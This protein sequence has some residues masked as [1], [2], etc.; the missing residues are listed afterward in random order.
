MG[1]Q[2]LSDSWF[3]EAERIRAEVNP[4]VP[5]AVKDL[6]INLKV[7]GGPSGDI[8]AKIASGRFEKGLADVAP[9]T[10]SVPYDTAK[11]MFIEGDQ[12]ATMQAFMSGIIK[13]EGDMTKLMAMQAGGPPSAEAEKVSELVKAMTD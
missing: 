11:S 7:T 3:D 8:E 9:T 5:E 6:V 2:F 1:H 12:N 10:L 13:V 4:E